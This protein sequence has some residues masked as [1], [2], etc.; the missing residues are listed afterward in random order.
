MAKKRMFTTDII[1]SDA[2]LDL[3]LSAQALYFHLNMRADDDGFLGNPKRVQRLV[4]ASD[5]D[6]KLLI[7]KKFLI[8]FEDGVIVIKHWRMHN[9]LSRSRYHETA[10]TD[11]K[12]QLFIKRNKA[13]SLTEGKPLNDN[14]LLPEEYVCEMVE[15]EQSPDSWRANGEQTAN[16]RRTVGEQT[17][18]SCRT[19]GEQNVEQVASKRRAN[20]EQNVPPGLGLGLGLGLDPGLDPGLGLEKESMGADAPMPP[21]PE[22]SKTRNAKKKFTPP[23]AEEVAEYAAETGRAIDAER[24][25]DFY[26]SKGWMV[27][28]NAMK[29]WKAAVR[30]WTRGDRQLLM[31]TSSTQTNYEVNGMQTDNVFLKLAAKYE[32]QEG[33]GRNGGDSS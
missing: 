14:D 33:S 18:N 23:S 28:K 32:N 8:A 21:A 20:G 11:K 7:A 12:D 1:D 24:F 10:Y 19:N 15:I 5:D 30:N 2:F 9:T 13:Y 31:Q 17:S 22:K 16:K 25:V 26:A 27:G 3:P 4:S 29:D 6:L